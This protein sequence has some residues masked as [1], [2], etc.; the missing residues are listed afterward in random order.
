M[1]KKILPWRRGRNGKNSN[2]FPKITEKSKPAK[3]KG[4]YSEFEVKGVNLLTLVN[5]LKNKGVNIL[6][7]K[8]KNNKTIRISINIGDEQKFFAITDKMCYN[9]K[10]IKNKGKMLWLYAL[11]S[12]K[13][14]VVGALC[15]VT[16]TIIFS[17]IVLGF[18]FSG[19]GSVYKGEILNYLSEQGVTRFSRFSAIDLPKLSDKMLADNK[20]FSFVN[21]YK[22]GNRLVI[23]L[24]IAQSN[25]HIKGEVKGDF[26]A[27]CGGIV[28]EISVYRGTAQVAVG[29]KVNAGEVLV[30]GYMEIKNQRIEVL[31]L[32]VVT[33]LV[34][35]QKT[36]ISDKEDAED[37]AITFLEGELNISAERATVEK[38]IKNGKYYYKVN[39]LYKRV[40]YTG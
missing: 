1:H 27:E 32:A 30:A 28:E 37:M 17:D 31:P 15:F 33:V 36:Y 4:V 6:D 18:T 39:L 11:L 12:R 13:S 23:D 22:K 9:V 34:E 8:S 14:L 35:A 26:Y 38:E 24:A 25:T 10:K 21:C 2:P 40:L 19:S 29:Q 20:R 7:L 16:L 5:T 3:L